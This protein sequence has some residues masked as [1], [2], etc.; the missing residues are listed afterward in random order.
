MASSS[1][2]TEA[3]FFMVPR[4]VHGPSP[5]V[6]VTR[7]QVNNKQRRL[8]WGDT[9]WTHFIRCGND[10]FS[11]V[12]KTF[13]SHNQNRGEE[14]LSDYYSWVSLYKIRR[15][16]YLEEEPFQMEID[17][18]SSTSRPIVVTLDGRCI[19]F[20]WQL[21]PTVSLHHLSSH[22]RVVQLPSLNC[23]M[24]VLSPQPS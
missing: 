4:T 24:L 20:C 6:R 10:P 9:P 21:F 12:D 19:T 14:A 3:T 23:I 8:R 22:V 7:H 11:V 13:I 1:S 5:G 16:I 18:A 2:S 15:R 17:A